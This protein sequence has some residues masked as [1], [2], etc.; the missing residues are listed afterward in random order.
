MRLHEIISEEAQRGKFTMKLSSSESD[1]Y[2]GT[3]DDTSD[4]PEETRRRFRRIADRYGVN[5]VDDYDEYVHSDN[6]RTDG[7]ISPLSKSHHK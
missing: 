5:V 2:M 7:E 1:D 3:E 4:N 6:K